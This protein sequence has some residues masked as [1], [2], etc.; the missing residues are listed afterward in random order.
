MKTSR[1]LLIYVFAALL[2]SPL[3]GLGQQK[4]SL[5][6]QQ[7]FAPPVLS[8]GVGGSYVGQKLSDLNTVYGDLEK[9]LSLPSGKD[10]TNPYDILLWL[11]LA[12]STTQAFQAEYG[13]SVLKSSAA[14]STNFLQTYYGGGSYILSLPLS[15]ASIYVGG[16]A[17]YLWLNSQRTYSTRVGVAQENAQL[18]QLHAL[19]GL[20]FF[21]QTGV[22]LSLEGRYNYASTVRPTRSDLNFTMKG[23]A[24]GIQLGIPIIM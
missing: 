12:P 1:S 16:G 24:G 5:V 2:L 14:K 20:Q 17:G 13:G 15:T 19:F 3:S 4:Q 7:K 22:S 21:N 11:R 18:A 10:F 9:S 8:I 23:I 6:I